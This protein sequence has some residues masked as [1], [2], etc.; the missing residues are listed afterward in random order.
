MRT[1]IVIAVRSHNERHGWWHPNLG[2]WVVSLSAES[3]YQVSIHSICGA[4][5]PA[6][7]SNLASEVFLQEHPDAEWLGIVDNDCVPPS[8]MLRI[9]D[10]LPDDIAVIGPVSHMMQHGHIKVQQGFLKRPTENYGVLETGRVQ[11]DIIG[12]G[13]WFVRRRVFADMV[14]P[15]FAEEYYPN[16][17]LKT[18]DDIYFQDKARKLGFKMFC[19]TRFVISHYHTADLSLIADKG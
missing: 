6:C 3:H 5:N 18:S 9:L 2:M 19:D 4:P 1:P 12:G 14:M 10:N 7:G 17:M 15:Y 13:C 11:V 8:N 16:F